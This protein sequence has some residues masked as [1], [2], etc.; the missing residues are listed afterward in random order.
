MTDTPAASIGRTD[1][2][3]DV[4]AAASAEALSATLDYDT[5][6]LEG[7]PLPLLWHWMFFKPMVRQSLIAAD[8]HPA[9]GGFLPDLG[10]PRRMWAGGRLR[11]HTPLKIGDRIIRDS[12]IADVSVKEGR[13]GKLAFVTVKHAIRTA[14]SLAIE[15]EHDIVYRE[16]ALPG[17]P[18]PSPTKPPA[19]E[20]WHRALIPDE[21]LLFRYSA[22]TFNGHRI[23]YDK[24]YVTGIESYPGLVVHGPLIATLLMDLIR[25]NRPEARVLD[26]AFKAIRPSFAANAL[27][28]CGRL[29]PDETTAELWAKDHEGWLT[30]SARATLA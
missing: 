19:D 8:G 22:V 12:R 6:P 4:V 16:P 29:S 11:F 27:T 14:D 13:S 15:E 28:L 21:V 2:A 18:A 9:K 1:S 20:Q 25:R 26:F 17:A 10:L 7:E 24:P 30:M 23:H 5:V 3:A